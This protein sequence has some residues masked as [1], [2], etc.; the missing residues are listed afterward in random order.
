LAHNDLH[1]R[2]TLWTE[3]ALKRQRG[4]AL[5]T[6]VGDECIAVGALVSAGRQFKATQRAIKEQRRVTMRAVV[7]FFTY[8]SAAT[9]AEQGATLVAESVFQK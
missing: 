6:E 5:H 4:A 7:I 8:E 2:A 3:I 9:R 1:G